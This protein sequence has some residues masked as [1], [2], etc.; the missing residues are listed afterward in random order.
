MSVLAQLKY[1]YDQASNR[2]FR[3][4]EVA[5]T[6][7]AKFDEVYRYD[8]LERLID[9]D[10]GELNSSNTGLVGFPGLTQ[11][12]T[13]DPT[14]NWNTFDQGIVDLL[15]QTRTH[16]R[17]N[18][19]ETI[20]TIF[21]LNW[22]DPD[23]DA[24]GNMTSLP[25]PHQ[26][27][28]SYTATWDAWNRLVKLED[29]SGTV[30]EY[31]YDGLNRR[32]AKTTGSTT[33]RGYYSDQ[34]QVLEERVGTSTSADSQYL[35]GVRYVDDLVLR[36]R[37]SERL[38]SLSDALF[39]VVALTDATGA[40]VERFAYEPYG[41]SE[42][43]NPNYTPYSGSDHQWSY[44]YTGRELDLETGLQINRMRYL[45]LQLGRWISRDPIDLISDNMTGTNNYTYVENIPLGTVDPMGLLGTQEDVLYCTGFLMNV[46][47]FAWLKY[48]CARELLGGFLFKQPRPCPDECIEAL[49]SL[50]SE[51]I[52]DS[53]IKSKL[54]S[55]SSCDSSGTITINDRGS[56]TF[57]SGDLH[58]AFN[59][60]RWEAEG[61]CHWSCGKPA[62]QENDS[63]CLCCRCDANCGWEA[64]VKDKYDFCS[65]LPKNARPRTLAWCGCVLESHGK[66]RVF[67]VRCPFTEEVVPIRYTHCTDD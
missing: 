35:W 25:Q 60:V 64:V 5:H 10:R 58:Y 15:E 56:Y 27:D 45:H 24:G 32:I 7:A 50:N 22:A 12:W 47:K 16:N 20:S 17:V 46:W 43:F 62:K 37:G 67:N 13:L 9:F 52:F 26:L 11:D 33:R 59:A 2:T 61:L 53:G 29:T 19:I 31:E 23:Y 8:G 6:H 49:K 38:Y 54:I 66:G 18:E 30:S 57:K 14:G 34:W 65:S 41:E 36:D 48:P 39:N 4:D 28:E 44:R 63:D 1:G 51:F 55:R 42:S 21:G 3:R 40:V